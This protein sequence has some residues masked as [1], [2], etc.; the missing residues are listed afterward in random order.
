M[1]FAAAGVEVGT[2]ARPNPKHITRPG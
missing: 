2:P 1:P